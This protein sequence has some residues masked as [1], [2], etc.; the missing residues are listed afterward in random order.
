MGAVAPT[1]AAQRAAL[2]DL[3]LAT[4]GSGW[5]DKAGWQ[6]YTSGSDPCDNIWSGVSC[7]GTVGAVNRSV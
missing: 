4:N 2:I 6:N 1:V 7:S 3:Y 5:T